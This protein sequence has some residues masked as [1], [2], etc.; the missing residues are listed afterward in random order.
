ML[1]GGNVTMISL[2]SSSMLISKDFDYNE[3]YRTHLIVEREMSQRGE[4]RRDVTIHRAR[5]Y[6]P[7]DMRKIKN[8]QQ[9]SQICLVYCLFLHQLPDPMEVMLSRGYFCVS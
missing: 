8:R 5:K 9:K 2:L 7:E 1:L 6:Y 3:H 4:K